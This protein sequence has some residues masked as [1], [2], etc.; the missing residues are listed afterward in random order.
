MDILIRRGSSSADDDHTRQQCLTLKLKHGLPIDVVKWML[1]ERL[2]LSSKT[3]L[4][5]REKDGGKHVQQ[6]QYYM[7]HLIVDRV[8]TPTTTPPSLLTNGRNKSTNT[9]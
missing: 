8:A 4:V 6:L 2:H 9:R 7:D 1:C 3:L 5:F